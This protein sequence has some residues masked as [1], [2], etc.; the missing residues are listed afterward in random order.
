M[1]FQAGLRPD[2][3]LGRPTGLWARSIEGVPQT[4]VGGSPIAPAN[5]VVQF[6]QYTGEAEA[7]TVGEGDVWVF[8][9]GVL[10]TGR[11]VRPD[12]AQPAKYV[13]GAG[14]PILL[15]PGRTWV[16]LLPV[17]ARGRR[18][19]RHR[20]PETT[21]APGHRRAAATTAKKKK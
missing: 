2:L 5:V 10:R 3:D 14:N 17:G 21:A 9:D 6:T 19:R 1:G 12:K 13:D 20:A 15:R 4:V 8:T 18:H 7:Q 11:W 16:E